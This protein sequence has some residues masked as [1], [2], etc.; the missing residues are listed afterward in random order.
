MSLQFNTEDPLKERALVYE[1][2]YDLVCRMFTVLCIL[3]CYLVL[4]HY[5]KLVALF[6]VLIYSNFDYFYLILHSIAYKVHNFNTFISKNI[7]PLL[8]NLH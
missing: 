5:Y 6:S 1:I 8:I 3:W 7:F 2:V 4:L